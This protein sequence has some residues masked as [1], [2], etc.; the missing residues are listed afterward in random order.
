MAQTLESHVVY[1][2]ISSCCMALVEIKAS[3]R[4]ACCLTL[5]RTIAAQRLCQEVQ[6][7]HGH[8][9]G[10][11]VIAEI[12]EP[13][14]ELYQRGGP[15]ALLLSHVNVTYHIAALL[16]LSLSGS[17][18]VVYSCGAR[19]VQGVCFRARRA[20]MH[21]IPSYGLGRDKVVVCAHYIVEMSLDVQVGE[22]CTSWQPSL[23]VPCISSR[24]RSEQP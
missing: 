10:K 8:T 12:Q 1:I 20:R 19:C 17:S 16:L 9:D 21:R 5:R 15:F 6:M 3:S 23:G 2:C 13:S 11:T 7:S 22:A 14:R 18:M 4:L 24:R